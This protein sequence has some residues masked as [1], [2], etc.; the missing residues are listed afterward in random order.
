MERSG[1]SLLRK[2]IEVNRLRKGL[3]VEEALIT[4]L[5]GGIGVIFP[6]HRFVQFLQQKALVFPHAF[7]ELHVGDVTEQRQAEVVLDF[8]GVME[9]MVHAVPQQACCGSGHQ[10]EDGA[11][12]QVAGD[13]WFD[14]IRG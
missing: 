7:E 14:R 9:H 10:A 6:D 2:R 12:G 4:A 8:A 13:R 11:K 5:F 3:L 1:W